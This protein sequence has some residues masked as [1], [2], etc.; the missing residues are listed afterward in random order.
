MYETIPC[1]LKILLLGTPEAKYG[2]NHLFSIFAAKANTTHMITFHSVPL[3]ANGKFDAI[4]KAEKLQFREVAGTSSE[5][6]F[7]R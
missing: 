2:V 5:S 1:H 7:T 4:F 3:T 6:S